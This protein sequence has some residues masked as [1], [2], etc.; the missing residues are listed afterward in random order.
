MDLDR[1]WRG[2]VTFFT[3]QTP[4]INFEKGL[5]NE[6]GFEASKAEILNNLTKGSR[7]HHLPFN[8]TMPEE[9][10]YISILFAG[11]LVSCRLYKGL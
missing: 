10:F 5:F 2:G 8:R 3:F 1:H 7:S 4:N 11:L 6:I 9:C